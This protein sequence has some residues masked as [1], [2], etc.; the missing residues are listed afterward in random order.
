MAVLFTA[1]LYHRHWV[2]AERRACNKKLLDNLDNPNSNLKR[3]CI[4]EYLK[5]EHIATLDPRETCR[6][7]HALYH[8]DSTRFASTNNGVT[9]TLTVTSTQ[10]CLDRT[11]IC[12]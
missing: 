7:R 3:V 10:F 5:K 9:A 8:I 1:T 4:V 11:P 6:E 12:V 2:V